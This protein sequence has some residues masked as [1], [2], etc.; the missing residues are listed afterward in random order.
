MRATPSWANPFF[1]EEAYHLAKLRSEMTGFAWHVD[2]VVPLK[3]RIVCGLHVEH[4]LAVVPAPYNLSKGN[5]H[6]PDM[7]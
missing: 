2:H 4:N 7:P 3:S 1:I 6:W 5:R